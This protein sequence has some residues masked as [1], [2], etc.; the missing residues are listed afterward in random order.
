MLFLQGMVGLPSRV[1]STLAWYQISQL[2]LSRFV[3]LLSSIHLPKIAAS[4]YSKLL[5]SFGENNLV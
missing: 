4:I 1:C 5:I 3:F 2:Y